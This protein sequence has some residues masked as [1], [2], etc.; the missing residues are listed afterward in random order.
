MTADQPKWEQALIQAR[1]YAFQAE[2]MV[3]DVEPTTADVALVSQA[4]SALANVEI[5]VYERLLD[6]VDS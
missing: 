5:A 6:E 3:R 2:R 4:F 1:Y